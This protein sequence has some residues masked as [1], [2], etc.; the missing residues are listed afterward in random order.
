MSP[1][2][3]QEPKVTP[4]G[5]MFRLQVEPPPIRHS[6]GKSLYYHHYSECNQ[7]LVFSLSSAL[8]SFKV[9]SRDF[10]NLL[11]PLNQ[12]IEL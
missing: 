4:A 1:S 6:G 11:R 3:E 12:T 7:C 8:G 10:K 2:L 9:C 5:M